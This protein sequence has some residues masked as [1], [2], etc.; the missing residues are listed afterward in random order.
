MSTC[1][2]VFCQL[3]EPERPNAG[4]EDAAAALVQISPTS[5]LLFLLHSPGGGGGRRLEEEDISGGGRLLHLSLQP[6]PHQ[7][8]PGLGAHT[9]TQITV[10]Y[11]AREKKEIKNFICSPFSSF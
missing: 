2:L 1:L 11:L 7:P 3:L 5:L 9:H 10:H 8:Q 4:V 6:A